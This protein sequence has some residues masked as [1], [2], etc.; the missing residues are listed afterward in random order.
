M[1]LGRWLLEILWCLEVGFW[2]LPGRRTRSPSVILPAPKAFGVKTI[3]VHLPPTADK[4]RHLKLKTCYKKSRLPH[5]TQSNLI[6][7]LL[8]KKIPNFF[9]GALMGNHWQTMQKPAEKPLK[10]VQKTRDF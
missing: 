5:Q 1:R 2:M 3:R 9:P 8:M 6:K 4:L 10:N 7:G